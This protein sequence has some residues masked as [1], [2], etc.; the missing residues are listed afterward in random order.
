MKTKNSI[1]KMLKPWMAI[2]V[3]FSLL[4]QSVFAAT[5]VVNVST[6]STGG[7]CTPGGDLLNDTCSL[8]EALSLS[9]NNSEAD[10]I[11]FDPSFP[12]MLTPAS[13]YVLDGY[14]YGISVDGELADA[15]K[16]SIQAQSVYNDVFD[17]YESNSTIQNFIILGGEAGIHVNSGTTNVS[18]LNNQ[19]GLSADDIE[20]PNTYGVRVTSYSDYSGSIVGNTISGNTY[21]I[22]IEASGGGLS[23]LQ[24]YGNNIGTDSTGTDDFGND[25]GLYL[26]WN[27]YSPGLLPFVIGDATQESNIIAGND[28]YGIYIPWAYGYYSV[29]VE[30][31][32][33]VIGLASTGASFGNSI[34]IAVANPYVD[35]T[36]GN[37]GDE[38]DDESEG[39]VISGNDSYSVD[40]DSAYGL[41]I[42]G[43]AIGTDETGTDTGI[44]NYGGISINGYSFVEVIEIIDNVIA[45]A[46]GGSTYRALEIGSSVSSNLPVVI[47]GNYFGLGLDGVAD[48]GEY[49]YGIFVNGGTL[50]FGGVNNLE[51]T[52]GEDIGQG[53]VVANFVYDRDIYG[54]M[55]GD[56]AALTLSGGSTIAEAFIYGNV[57][58]L[59]RGNSGLFD[60]NAGNS[61]GDIQIDSDSLS[62]VEIGAVDLDHIGNPASSVIVTGYLDEDGFEDLSQLRNVISGYD[63]LEENEDSHNGSPALIDL[64]DLCDGVTAEGGTPDSC[65]GA[66]ASIV[67]VVNN[68]IGGTITVEGTVMTGDGGVIGGIMNSDD[69]INVEDGDYV[70]IGCRE[71]EEGFDTCD[72]NSG[73]IIS[74]SNF[75]I[76]IEPDYDTYWDGMYHNMEDPYELGGVVRILGNYV[77]VDAS[78]VVGLPNIFG[79]FVGA[80]IPGSYVYVG[81]TGEEGE[82]GEY[83][84]PSPLQY[85]RNVIS[86]NLVAN[87]M[88]GAMG[89]SDNDFEWWDPENDKNIINLKGNY[90]GPNANGERL[91]VVDL[92]VEMTD[93][94]EMFESQYN[95]DLSVL[96]LLDV[97]DIASGLIGFIMIDPYEAVSMAVGG[98][99]DEERNVIPGNGFAGILM[100]GVS[101]VQISGNY[102]G[103]AAD[104]E[105]ALP[106][107]VFD[108]EV[109]FNIVNE[110]VSQLGDEMGVPE[111]FEEMLVGIENMFED[112]LEHI[113]GAGIAAI[114]I[115]FTDGEET[116][117]LDISDVTIADN[118]IAG[119]EGPGLVLYHLMYSVDEIINLFD[120]FE[121]VSNCEE[122]CGPQL[123][124][125]IENFTIGGGTQTWD[126]ESISNNYFG[127]ASDGITP[128]E[129]TGAA[130]SMINM[131]FE[132]S[133]GIKFDGGYPLAGNTMNGAVYMQVLE[134]DGAS[135]EWLANN[136][137][138][139]NQGLTLDTYVDPLWFDLYHWVLY[140]SDEVENPD[141]EA[142]DFVIPTCYW[143]SGDSVLC[144]VDPRP[145]TTGRGG[146]GYQKTEEPEDPEVIPEVISDEEPEVDVPD[147][148]ITDP[149]L[150]TGEDVS[151]ETDAEVTEEDSD[152][153]TIEIPTELGLVD[154]TKVYSDDTYRNYALALVLDSEACVAEDPAVCFA[155]IY[156][157]PE[158]T[159]SEKE[160]TDAVVFGKRS[161]EV[162]VEPR[163]VNLEGTVGTS[164]AILV[165][166]Q[167]NEE[168][169]VE[170]TEKAEDPA[171]TDGENDV[172]LQSESASVV[173]T[174]TGM[175]DDEGKAVLTYTLP[176]GNY[177]AAVYVQRGLSKVYGKETSEFTVDSSVDSEFF[178]ED[179]QVNEE[180][181]Y[182]RITKLLG[183]F[184]ENLLAEVEEREPKFDKDEYIEYKRTGDKIYVVRGKVRT[185][186]QANKIVYLTYQSVTLG[187]AIIADAS[188]EGVFMAKVPKTLAADTHEL[189]AFAYDPKQTKSTSA[190][191][192]T[193][194]KK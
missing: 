185:A 1:F 103:L 141:P 63:D 12:D 6:D 65:N 80:E 131:M 34:G 159:L 24:I 43:N 175:T 52:D 54:M 44:R 89:D 96:E 164:P 49:G 23:G 39:N 84:N 123:P 182:K 186:D 82:I 157:L 77:G 9:N 135:A 178:V 50:I 153:E 14:D 165:L 4:T 139:I 20:V 115:G 169:F 95:A 3:L 5:Y 177:T 133:D 184:S 127:L 154:S 93:L 78:G 86:G 192:L 143:A 71:T 92:G 85:S 130:I 37:D 18:I 59:S 99:S 81:Y 191:K 31:Q 104:G 72:E 121:S 149:W 28:M 26:N 47:Q 170:I 162:V 17:V 190:A 172:Q 41:R 189:T 181:E 21:G 94:I 66:D 42:A 166:S 193:F 108:F 91:E 64:S 51:A 60:T 22:Y 107:G 136:L 155:K 7:T 62:Y 111:G 147:V 56:R 114:D 146:G 168:V 187:S 2:L 19:I 118:Y 116:M 48:L 58:G 67:N 122:D 30:I 38:V 8:R 179:V 119:N 163:I 137:T 176:A 167:P 134:D 106:N 40:V 53:N 100:L 145:R 125:G 36:I 33:N 120:F 15:E 126:G 138:L 45:G 156:G 174:V 152:E 173:N 69:G 102:I 46:T 74:G 10:S 117:A 124:E 129:N 140:I 110:V 79:L 97:N 128:V 112:V 194:E 144:G 83:S 132:G 87:V 76:D 148:E 55:I 13:P 27:T 158:T 171:E 75:G 57:F 188:Q 88:T 68:Y 150:G 32:N 16:V 101:N 109:F 113:N 70:N 180:Y 73:N 105:T 160:F 98:E 25:Y 11:S 35:L 142:D 183:K 90:I 151:N 61:V 29:P 161:G